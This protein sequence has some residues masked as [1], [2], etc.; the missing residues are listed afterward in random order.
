MG[1][2]RGLTPLSNP[3]DL[4]QISGLPDPVDA[5]ES[6]DERPPLALR[7]HDVSEDIHAALG[8]QDLHQRLLQGLLD[9]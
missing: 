1:K 8:L 6:D 3:T 2:L 4:G 9:C 5:A 7:L